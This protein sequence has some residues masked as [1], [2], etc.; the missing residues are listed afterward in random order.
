[1][2]ILVTGSTGFIGHALCLSLAQFGYKTR[3][4]VRNNSELLLSEGNGES[5]KNNFVVGEIGRSTKWLQVLQDIDTVIHLAARVHMMQNKNQDPLAA[6]REVNT[7]GTERL[8]GEASKAG[9]RRFIYLSSIKVNG[10]MTGRNEKERK[11]RFSEVD[12]PDPQD[13]YAISKWEAEQALQAISQETGMELVIIRPPLVYGPGAKENFLRV[14]RWLDKGMP[15]PLGAI[16]NKRSL[17]A[18]DNLVDLIITCI[19]NPAAANQTFLVADGED[20]S[21]TEL[22][23][24]LGRVLG[25]PARLLPVPE[26][27]LKFSLNVIGK[28]DLSQRLCGSLQ[29]DISKTKNML[30][31][32]PPVSLDDGLMKTAEWYLKQKAIG[33]H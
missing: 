14:L 11:I 8:A 4:A 3:C 16:N 1:V 25:K 19:D 33:S 22:V 10:E 7:A 30:G 29:V 5:I 28:S 24:R 9:V 15:L 32:E 27:L 2:A 13:L 17:V 6:F 23:R 18:L 21:T 31:W 12:I 20:V 26:Q